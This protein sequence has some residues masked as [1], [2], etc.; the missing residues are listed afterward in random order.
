MNTAARI[1]THRDHSKY[2][3]KQKL[4]QRGFASKVID[5]VIGE[6]ER[7]N[8]IDDPR[9]AHVY[10]SQLKK[11][12]FGKRYIRMA[13]RKKRLSGAVIKKILLENY[14]EAEEHENAGKL[15]KKKMK[16]FNREEDS[17]KRRDK[18]YRFLYSRGFNKDVITDLIRDLVK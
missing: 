13:L 7:L 15:L 5:T 18:I 3:L 16:T 1:L 6:C 11:K 10:I 4:Q 2:E 12:C 9:T 17:K 8:Y 14:T